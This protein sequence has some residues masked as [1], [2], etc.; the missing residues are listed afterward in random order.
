MNLKIY[1]EPSAERENTQVQVRKMAMKLALSSNRKGEA[2]VE[3]PLR[4]EQEKNSRVRS[5]DSTGL[6]SYNV[7]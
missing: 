5:S 3:S 6:R 1:L 7:N 2:L 4:S